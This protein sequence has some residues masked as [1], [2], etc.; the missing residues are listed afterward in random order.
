MSKVVI[1][2]KYS[3]NGKSVG[4]RFT[5]YI[6]RRDRVDKTINARRSEVFPKYAAERP[7]VITMG[8]HGLFGQED[9]VNLHK[10]SKEIYNH[11]GIVWQ[12]VISLRQT[13]AER[14]G[15][16]TPEAWR[17]LL[18]S[19]QFEIASYHRIPAENMKWYAAFHKEEGHYHVHFL[20]FNK[21]PG[22]EFLCERDYFRYKDSLTKT[23]FKD[24]M[25]Q[26]YDE[27]QSLRDKIVESVKEKM[28]EFSADIGEAPD[29]FAESF[30]DL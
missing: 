17:N 1:R 15:Y 20:L 29:G 30:V 4:G 8:E 16:D 28:S 14:L 10:A 2:T 21:E 3:S 18:R 12:Q 24:E 19:K 27:R 5:N 9:Y 25:K 22:G 23:I 11:N 26:L 7:G 6:S 13:D